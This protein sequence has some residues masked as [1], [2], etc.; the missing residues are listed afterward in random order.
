MDFDEAV[1]AHS[2]WKTKLRAYLTKPDKS[3]NPADIEADNRCPLGR[4]LHGEGRAHSA[5]P[6]FQ[7]LRK[8]HANFHLAA[9]A[10][11]RRADHGENVSDETLLGAK[12]PFAQLSQR[13]VHLIIMM[14]Q[15]SP[16]SARR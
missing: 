13:L 15:K 6:D 16:V 4:W 11:V 8:E 3:L 12:S 9:A 10:L 7:E 1:A 5:D 14:K 2:H